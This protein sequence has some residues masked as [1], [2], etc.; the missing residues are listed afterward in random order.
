MGPTSVSFVEQRIA[1][2]SVPVNLTTTKS[3]FLQNTGVNHGYFQV[4]TAYGK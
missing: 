4:D 3:A 1:F 2:G